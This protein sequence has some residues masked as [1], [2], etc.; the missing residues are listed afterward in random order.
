MSG[1]TN[2]ESTLWRHQRRFAQHVIQKFV[3]EDAECVIQNELREM[4]A[5]LS[6]SD[7]PKTGLHQNTVDYADLTC[8]VDPRPHLSRAVGNVIAKL[9]FS[10][11]MSAELPELSRSLNDA[12][13]RLNTKLEPLIALLGKFAHLLSYGNSE[14]ERN[15]EDWDYET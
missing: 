9:I 1:L 7:Y 13:G 14:V 15:I 4:V 8:A 6:A 2:S 10:K 3:R 12:C 5:A 11:R